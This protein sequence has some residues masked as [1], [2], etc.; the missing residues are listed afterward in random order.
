VRASNGA[1]TFRSIEPASWLASRGLTIAAKGNVKGALW[2]TQGRK[3]VL[4][5]KVAACGTRLPTPGAALLL[6]VSVTME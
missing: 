2:C 6:P 5:Q 3:I 4:P 1:V